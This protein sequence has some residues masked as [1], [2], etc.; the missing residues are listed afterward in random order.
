MHTTYLSSGMGN[1]QTSITQIGKYLSTLEEEF[2]KHGNTVAEKKLF[3]AERFIIKFRIV[4]RFQHKA[5]CDAF[6]LR[7]STVY[8]LY[9]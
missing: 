1:K 4:V 9:Y 8:Q 7:N 5:G 3:F 6:Y 2:K